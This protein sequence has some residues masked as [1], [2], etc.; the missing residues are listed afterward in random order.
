MQLGININQI[1]KFRFKYIINTIQLYPI[2]PYN[3]V[4][5]NL[6]HKNCKNRNIAHPNLHPV[7]N[8]NY[9]IRELKY[10]KLLN[11]LRFSNYITKSTADLFN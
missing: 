11:I 9:L 10:L 3:N 5:K 7:I 1:Q 8:S 4:C 2:T 6:Q